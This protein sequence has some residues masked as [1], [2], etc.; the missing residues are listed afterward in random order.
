MPRCFQT[1]FRLNDSKHKI[2]LLVLTAAVLIAAGLAGFRIWSIQNC[3]KSTDQDAVKVV[4][5]YLTALKNNDYNTWKS[6][7]WQFDEKNHGYERKGD[8]AVQSLSIETVRLSAQETQRIRKQ[9]GDSELAKSHG[10]TNDFINN[11]LIA[12]YEHYSAKYDHTKVS[13][14]DGDIKEYVYLVRRS[15]YS[16]WLIWTF[17]GEASGIEKND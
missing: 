8:L 7:L 13:Y 15:Q 9:Y 1:Y 3:V 14:T 5:T 6:C 2:I 12:V 11:N 4:K 10:W 17:S 16:P